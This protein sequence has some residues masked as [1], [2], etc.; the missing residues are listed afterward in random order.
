MNFKYIPK[1]YRDLIFL[2]LTFYCSSVSAK[3]YITWTGHEVDKAASIWLIKKYIDFNSTFSYQE[4]G[5]T[6]TKKEITGFT[7]D[8]PNSKFKRSHQFTTFDTLIQHFEIKEPNLREISNIVKD[9]EL[10]HWSL[11]PS[12]T[13][14]KVNKNWKYYTDNYAHNGI[15]KEECIYMFF[16]HIQETIKN[17]KPYQ[18]LSKKC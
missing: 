9:I 14:F 8:M 2:L 4:K 15:I 12:S 5:S 11:D 17:K 3:E 1:T 18:F 7:F 10:S 16:D 13:S 6:Y